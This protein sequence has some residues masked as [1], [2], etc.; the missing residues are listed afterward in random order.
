MSKKNR[1]N[2]VQELVPVPPPPV[3]HGN[4]FHTFISEAAQIGN[5]VTARREFDRD[6]GEYLESKGLTA[7]FNAYRA[8]KSKPKAS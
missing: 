6:V 2:K 8:A 4:C 7:D 3:L 5:E 1:P